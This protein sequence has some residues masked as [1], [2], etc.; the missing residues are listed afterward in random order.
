ML[1][2][3]IKWGAEDKELVTVCYCVLSSLNNETFLLS[4]KEH[5][6]CLFFHLFYFSNINQSMY[7]LGLHSLQLSQASSSFACL[8]IIK[9]DIVH[10]MA[11]WTLSMFSLSLFS[12]GNCS[13]IPLHVWNI[14]PSFIKRS[15]MSRMG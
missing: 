8:W 7:V 14:A 2:N 6:F 9:H 4:L 1:E 11:S 5:I 13:V 10:G 15:W 12:P 3:W